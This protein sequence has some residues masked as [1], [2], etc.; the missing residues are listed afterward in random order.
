MADEQLNLGPLSVVP[1][2][3]I[4]K[5]EERFYSRYPCAA[6]ST[7]R[8]WS[9]GAQAECRATTLDIFRDLRLKR[10]SCLN[11]PHVA[12]LNPDNFRCRL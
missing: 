3:S 12:D 8:W 5:P 11:R 9:Q 2:P 6:A 10:H 7:L 1:F 4:Q